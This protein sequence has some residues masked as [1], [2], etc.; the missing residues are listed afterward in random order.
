MYARYRIMVDRARRKGHWDEENPWSFE[1]FKVWAQENGLMEASKKDKLVV[2][3]KDATKPYSRDNCRVITNSLN[4]SKAY[5]DKV[6]IHRANALQ[7]TG[8]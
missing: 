2:D 4:C 6:A 3:R 7:Q 8:I 5:A 1:D